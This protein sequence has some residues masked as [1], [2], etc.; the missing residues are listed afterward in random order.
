MEPLERKPPE[1]RVGW[2]FYAYMDFAFGFSISDQARPILV[3]TTKWSHLKWHFSKIAL[4]QRMYFHFDIK[5]HAILL[6]KFS[7]KN[8]QTS[9]STKYHF[10][11]RCARYGIRTYH[12][13]FLHTARPECGV[14]KWLYEP[15]QHKH[16]QYL[17]DSQLGFEI[18]FP[19]FILSFFSTRK[20]PQQ[21]TLCH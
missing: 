12:I 20:M 10:R 1:S 5:C 19:S 2:W 18:Q 15:L 21:Q 9:V 7:E 17:S 11:W 14:M 6:W 16:V 3:Q 13:T 4:K 8:V